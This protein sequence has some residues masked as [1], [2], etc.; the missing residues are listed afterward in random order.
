VNSNSLARF[1]R[2]LGAAFAA[3]TLAGLG[4]LPATP[5]GASPN[6]TTAPP[7]QLAA[8]D[9]MTCA[10]AAGKV[11]CWGRNDNGNLGDGTTTDRTTAVP[12]RTDGVLS[13]KT[14]VDIGAAG[15]GYN[16]VLDSA[17][18]PYCWGE[19]EHS[20]LGDGTTAN[21]SLPLAV[22]LGPM[23]G[24]QLR[25][26]GDQYDH[27]CA[28]DSTG[29]AFCWG[30]EDQGGLGNG[31]SADVNVTVPTAITQPVA[32]RDLS[33]GEHMTCAIGTDHRAYCWGDNDAG[34]VGDNSTIDRTT[35]VA[36]FTGGALSGK[37]IAQ[38]SAGTARACALDTAG[39]AYCWG[40]NSDGAL[41][42]GTTTNA[43]TPQAVQVSGVLAGKHLVRIE[44]DQHHTC[45]L[46]N[47]GAA[48]C[49]GNNSDG[50]LGIGNTSNSSSPAAVDVTGVPAGTAFTDI[51]L[52]YRHTC[53]QTANGRTYCWGSN[54][55]GQ[56]GDGT[57]T[58][59]SKPGEA[60]HNLPVAP[61]SPVDVAV[62]RT[63]TSADV[64][65]AAPADAGTPALLGYAVTAMPG[66]HACHSTQTAC[67]IDGLNPGT[68][69]RFTVSAL[70]V[71]GDSQNSLVTSTGSANGLPT[72]AVTGRNVAAVVLTGLGSVALGVVALRFGRRRTWATNS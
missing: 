21:S 44:T 34:G 9:R 5:A 40:D 48:Y 26:I 2:V 8:G 7:A 45:A 65:W 49:W 50:Q 64:S 36:V 23:A 22:T 59:H 29:H 37:S 61:G 68:T 58:S 6:V 17:G 42:D 24:K 20:Q 46:D 70:S 72:L 66:N 14:L 32:F 30:H 71:A 18:K 25:R 55:H 67:V 33:P 47:A 62:D 28:L 1:A 38:I 27:T 10:I 57:T 16:C 19:N 12:V 41:G 53:A 56:L 39:A 63:G 31:A 3:T 15:H 4:G 43:D 51:R 69:Y 35:P 13:G 52:G 54:N 60:V 11:Y